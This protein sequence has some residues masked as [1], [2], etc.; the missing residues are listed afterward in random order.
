MVRSWLGCRTINPAAGKRTIIVLIGFFTHA[1]KVLISIQSMILCDEPYL[2]EPGW[3]NSAGT[4]PSLAYSANVRRMVVKTAMLGN[5]RNPPEPFGDVIRTH[6]RLK[7]QS[8]KR[9]LD[10]WLSKDDG[11]TTAG[12][13][14]GFVGSLVRTDAASSNNGFAQDIEELKTL[15]DS[16]QEDTN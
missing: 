9:Q 15:L 11:K 14:G 6:F 13:G 4:P 1:E 8:I 12:D 10:E 3:A 5:L 2:N 16:L 7:A